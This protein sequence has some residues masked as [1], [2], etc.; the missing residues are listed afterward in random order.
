MITHHATTESNAII[1]MD[2]GTTATSSSEPVGQC[3]N[4]ANLMC[5]TDRFFQAGDALEN[6]ASRESDQLPAPK[7]P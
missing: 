6:S 1:L 2:D 3:C 4:S 5:D 7:S